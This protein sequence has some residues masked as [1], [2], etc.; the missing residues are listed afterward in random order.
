MRANPHLDVSNAS[1]PDED[2]QSPGSYFESEPGPYSAHRLRPPQYSLHSAS[3]NRFYRPPRS[4]S[5]TSSTRSW[6]TRE[7]SISDNRFSRVTLNGSFDALRG[8]PSPA[9]DE[10]VPF[11][12]AMCSSPSAVDD[13]R[14]SD[15][16]TSPGTPAE[17]ERTAALGPRWNDYSFRESDLYYGGRPRGEGSKTSDDTAVDNPRSSRQTSRKTLRQYIK[18]EPSG[19]AVP[20]KGFEVIR[21]PPPPGT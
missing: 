13:H 14:A 19:T 2:A 4:T 3:S 9:I 21:R 20:S 7:S 12:R 11:S 8:P 17:S 6:E 15:K 10:S 18:R 5:R 1:T 16:E